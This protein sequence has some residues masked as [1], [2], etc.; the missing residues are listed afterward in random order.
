MYKLISNWLV[1]D[2]MTSSVEINNVTSY[3]AHTTCPIQCRHGT[4]IFLLIDY[5]V[6]FRVNVNF[7]VDI[8]KGNNIISLHVKCMCFETDESNSNR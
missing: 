3:H 2:T 8:V 1:I 7:Y 4:Y 5:V 6:I